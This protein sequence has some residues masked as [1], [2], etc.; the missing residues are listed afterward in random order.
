MT[1]Y[2]ELQINNELYNAF[3]LKQKLHL[4]EKGC[5][6]VTDAKEPLVP[7][8]NHKSIHVCIRQA[9]SQASKT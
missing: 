7:Y 3:T 8:R 9:K 6:Q 4:P 5:I 2:S 1:Y